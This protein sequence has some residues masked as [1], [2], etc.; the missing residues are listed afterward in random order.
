MES[1]LPPSSP[2]GSI[3]NDIQ[4]ALD[5][6]LYYPALVVALTVP[7]ICVALTV[8]NSVFI[9]EAHYV[10]F[11]N[12]YTTPSEL[13]VDGQS[14]YRL[15]GGVVHR[16]NAAGHPFFGATNVMFA[17]PESPV[18]M[19]GMAL[20]VGD[21]VST[22]FV[23]EN[24]CNEMIAAAHRWYDDHKA[25]AK[26]IENMPKLLSYK[27]DGLPPFVSGSPMIGCEA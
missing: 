26:V 18:K 14:C 3:L 15:R 7:E 20:Q 23:L 10:A 13:G 25:D 6:Q 4:R 17:L 27:P 11:V 5:A 21:K 1:A 22:A 8:D 16:G 24:F 2:L 19:H 9:R 12:K